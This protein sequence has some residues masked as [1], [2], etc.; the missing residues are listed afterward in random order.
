MIGLPIPRFRRM[1]LLRHWLNVLPLRDKAQSIA[2]TWRRISRRGL[3][4]PRQVVPHEPR[5]AI[6]ML[7]AASLSLS[8]EVAR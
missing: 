2:G 4:A 1:P 3:N 8:E 5:A 6:Q 7:S